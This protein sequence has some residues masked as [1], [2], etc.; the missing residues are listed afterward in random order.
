MIDPIP[1]QPS[2][3]SDGKNLGTLAESRCKSP[4]LPGGMLALGID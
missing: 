2:G 1:G 3:N 4:G